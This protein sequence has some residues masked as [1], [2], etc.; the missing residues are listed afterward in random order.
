MSSEKN[1]FMNI[2]RFF[3]ATVLFIKITYKMINVILKK[4]LILILRHKSYSEKV[5]QF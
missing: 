3:S 5:A 4:T 2:I 1:V